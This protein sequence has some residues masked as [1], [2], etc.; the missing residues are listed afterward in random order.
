[1]LKAA[2]VTLLL[3][4][5]PAAAQAAASADPLGT[6]T[7]QDI[8][9]LEFDGAEVVYDESFHLM[10]PETVE[11]AFSVPVLMNF[12]EAPFEVAEIA[13]FAENNPFPQVVRIYPHRP[14]DAVGFN[15]RLE[16]STPLRAAAMDPDGVW[17]IVHREV[18]V[19]TPGGCSAGAGGGSGGPRIGDISMRQFVRTDGESR[20]KVRIAHPM[21]T[22]L[23][24]NEFTGEAIP[25]Y[26]IDQVI[27]S[28]DKGSLARMLLWASIAANPT[29][30]LDLPETQQSVHISASDTDGDAFEI[31]AIPD[32]F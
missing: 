30:L 14:L 26:Y 5:A 7:W 11:E 31:D 10:V 24:T 20:L 18:F 16:R 28:D 15:I 27:I 21:D 13:L 1:M 2:T 32:E 3:A 19:G 12:V 29:I 22:G 6:E 25:A 8:L 9:D 4:I 17:H 23:A